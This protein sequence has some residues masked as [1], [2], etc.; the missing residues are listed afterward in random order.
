MEELHSSMSFI[1]GR[2]RVG[3]ESGREGERERKEGKERGRDVVREKDNEARD[4]G[5]EVEGGEIECERD[6]DRK[7]VVWERV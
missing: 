2:E 1:C 7:S 6:R 3:G 5:R 4:G